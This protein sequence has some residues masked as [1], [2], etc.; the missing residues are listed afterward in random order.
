MTLK[1]I[2]DKST[3]LNGLVKSLT[4]HKYNGNRA[5]ERL[6]PGCNSKMP[7][8]KW[9]HTPIFLPGGWQAMVHGVAKELDMT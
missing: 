1:L 8:P 4:L 5:N 2:Q 7:L 3:I 6:I 9:R